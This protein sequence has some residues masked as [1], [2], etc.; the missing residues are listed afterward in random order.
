MSKKQRNLTK[1]VDVHHLT[2]KQLAMLV[3]P[4]TREVLESLQKL[5]VASVGQLQSSLGVQSKTIYYQVQK[6]LEV[7]LIEATSQEVGPE[8]FRPVANHFVMPSGFQGVEYER[9]AAKGVESLLRRQT[10]QFIAAAEASEQN[11]SIVD[12]LFVCSASL[13]LAPS[14]LSEFKQEATALIRRYSALKEPDQAALD[15]AIVISPRPK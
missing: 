1:K 7:G 4:R 12:A 2:E 15:L 6:L 3:S 14:Q 10:R 11:P 5:Q 9:L 13:H 8:L